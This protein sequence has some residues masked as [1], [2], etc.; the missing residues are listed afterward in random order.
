ME[1]RKHLLG[2]HEIPIPDA[3]KLHTF[4]KITKENADN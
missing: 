2:R 4:L 1:R 3:F